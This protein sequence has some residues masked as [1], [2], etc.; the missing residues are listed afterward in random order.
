MLGRKLERLVWVSASVVDS[1]ERM[2]W[3][4][5]KR[6]P[7]VEPSVVTSGGRSDVVVGTLISSSPVV[8]ERKSSLVGELVRS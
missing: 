5:V 4:V 3:S 2:F 8:V 7:I 6:L 1:C